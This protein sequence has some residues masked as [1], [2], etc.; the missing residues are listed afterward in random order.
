VGIIPINRDRIRI[1]VDINT[2]CSEIK[3]A[4]DDFFRTQYNFIQTLINTHVHSPLLMHARRPYPYEHLQRTEPTDL[5]VNEVT[6]GASLLT[7]T[8][9]TTHVHSPLRMHARRPYPY[10][11]LQRTEPSDLEVNEVTI[12]A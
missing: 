5:E 8:S 12:G 7:D 11:H 4:P 6:T 3:C 10:E 2:W 1:R 9:P